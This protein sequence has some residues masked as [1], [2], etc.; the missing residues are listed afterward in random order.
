LKDVLS[1]G[2]E[3]YDAEKLEGEDD[4]PGTGLLLPVQE[5]YTVLGRA[6][7]AL[8]RG[9]QEAVLFRQTLDLPYVNRNDSRMSPNTF[10]AYTFSGAVEPGRWVERI[11]YVAGYV[12]KIKPRNAEKFI[13]MAKAAGAAGTDRGLVTAGARFQ[14]S[15]HLAMGGVNHYVED[16]INM[17]Y[18]AMD[19]T[20]DLTDEVALR[21]ESQFSHQ[22]SVGDNR[23]TG[24]AFDTWNLG[25]RAAVSF[26]RLV[27]KAALSTTDR[28]DRIRNP[29]GSYPG[30]VSLMQ[31]DFNR[32]GE[33]AWL[34]GASYD[35]KDWGLDGL[36]MFANY[37]EGT[38][39]RDVQG[40]FSD[41]LREFDVTAD[42]RF[43]KGVARGLWLRVR[44]STLD[45]EGVDDHS[46]DF[47]VTMNYELPLF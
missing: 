36:S 6:Y 42:Y 8:R 4:E 32:A 38:G 9:K 2:A 22:A 15:E 5:G 27:L 20:G 43:R 35:F 37:A 14:V 24:D 25:A 34:V 46:T 28:G 47:R 45:L 12:D 31:K 39:A 44:W 11:N 7:L 29:Y 40:V 1:V 30:Y 3:L 13:D 17:A 10:E 33:D 18:A 41:D 19:F 21:L 26:H 23:L 16:V